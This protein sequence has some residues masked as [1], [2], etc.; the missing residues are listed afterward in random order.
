MVFFEGALS[1][2][3][4]ASVIVATLRAGSRALYLTEHDSIGVMQ[5]PPILGPHEVENGT[6]ASPVWDLSYPF[7]EGVRLA[8]FPDSFQYQQDE[9]VEP[10]AYTMTPH[11]SNPVL[12]TEAAS[13]DDALNP[14]DLEYFDDLVEQ[15]Q[16]TEQLGQQRTK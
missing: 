14:E 5:G 3:A 13:T 15:P 1:A 8:L 2:L 12:E 16:H 10:E 11:S 9:I 6:E 4:Y 7:Q